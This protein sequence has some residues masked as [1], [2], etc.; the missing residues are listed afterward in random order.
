MQI[1]SLTVAPAA[2]TPAAA[3]APT[4][5]AGG[6]IPGWSPTLKA[7]LPFSTR[8][9]GLIRAGL[10]AWRGVPEQAGGVRLSQAMVGALT[11]FFAQQLKLDEAVVRQDLSKVQIVAGGPAHDAGGTATTIGHT[12][13]VSDAD[14]AQ[15]MLSW[16]GRRWL[17]HEL[18]HTMQWRTSADAWASPADRDRAFL[19]RYLGKFIADGGSISKGGLVTA[20]RTWLKQRDDAHTGDHEVDGVGD[21][22]HDSHPME[23]EAEQLARVFRDQT[24]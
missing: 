23:R 1:A 15:R 3:T 8:A 24:A 2:P 4:A 13:Y 19:N 18:V 10:D 20:L 21:V 12:I 14:R 6:P 16:K 11:P 17:A 9:K 7:G 22:I 5:A